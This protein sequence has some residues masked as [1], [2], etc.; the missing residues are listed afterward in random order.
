M[1]GRW[2]RA[3]AEPTAARERTGTPHTEETGLATSGYVD[4]GPGLNKHRPTS[5]QSTGRTA[6]GAR[7]MAGNT[8]ATPRFMRDHRK[9]RTFVPAD[10]LALAVYRASRRMPSEERYGLQ[11]QLRRAAVSAATN[12]VEGAAREPIR[13]YAHFLRIAFASAAEVAYLLTVV[14]RLDL[15]TSTDTPSLEAGYDELVRRLKRQ[16]DGLVAAEA[17]ERE[18]RKH[19]RALRHGP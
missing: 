3:L 14:R 1:T 10:T 19:G 11:A 15:T 13:E 8:L 5:A 9:L 12:I 17:R 18:V 6:H 7:P 16:I 2:D 4:G